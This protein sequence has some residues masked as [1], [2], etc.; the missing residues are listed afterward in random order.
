M[1]WV[2][3]FRQGFDERA[4]LPLELEQLVLVDKPQV[5]I[6]SKINQLLQFLNPIVIS[7]TPELFRCK[8][9]I[10]LT[11]YQIILNGKK[12]SDCIEMNL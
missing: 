1:G 3:A 9:I 11:I 8:Q 7:P 10:L 12:L 4:T 5:R 6:G 2:S